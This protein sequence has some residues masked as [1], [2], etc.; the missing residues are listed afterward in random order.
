MPSEEEL[1]KALAKRLTK[2]EIPSK[3]AFLKEM[4]LNQAG[5]PDKEYLKKLLGGK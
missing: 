2:I 3:I 1:K 5:K 4:P